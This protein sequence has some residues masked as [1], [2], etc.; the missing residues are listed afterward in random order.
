MK[1]P[2]PHHFAGSVLVIVLGGLLAGCA[3]SNNRNVN[4][5]EGEFSP[6]E[7]DLWRRLCKRTANFRESVN[8]GDPLCTVDDPIEIA[9]ID[10][11]Q[12]TIVVNASS[13]NRPNGLWDY[14]CFD[15][16]RA[17][18]GQWKGELWDSTKREQYFGQL[19]ESWAALKGDNRLVDVRPFQF[20]VEHEE[21]TTYRQARD[22][23]W[24]WSPLMFCPFDIAHLKHLT[25]PSHAPLSKQA[26]ALVSDQ[27][28]RLRVTAV[29]PSL[30]PAQY[31]RLSS[32]SWWRY[33]DQVGVAPNWSAS[34]V[35]LLI[36]GTQ[37]R[38]AAFEISVVSLSRDQVELNVR[39]L[40]PASVK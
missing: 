40:H 29:G 38:F 4:R 35:L 18:I 9:R 3:V 15:D 16:S 19:A 28:L 34:Q 21:G 23:K 24:Y 32:L 25:D 6:V 7:A 20:F 30:Q 12:S 33:E 2:I 31:G 27:S 37:F 1:M 11:P 14:Q 10:I 39:S 5:S 36:P 17:I 22:V 26:L 8:R 13:A